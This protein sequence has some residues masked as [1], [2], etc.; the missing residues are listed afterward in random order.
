[1]FTSTQTKYL[2]ITTSQNKQERE[3]LFTY[4]PKCRRNKHNKKKIIKKE[5]LYYE[6]TSM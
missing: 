3:I 1:M 6:E 4:K 5:K 2:Y